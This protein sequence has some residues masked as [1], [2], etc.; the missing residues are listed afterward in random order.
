MTPAGEFLAQRWR[1]AL[2]VLVLAELVA[3]ALVVVL[4]FWR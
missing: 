4:G 3:L 2:R 1:P